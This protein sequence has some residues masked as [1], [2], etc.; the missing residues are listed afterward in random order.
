MAPFQ[1]PWTPAL[2]TKDNAHFSEYELPSEGGFDLSTSSEKWELFFCFLILLLCGKCFDV[3][4]KEPGSQRPSLWALGSSRR[5][6]R[7]QPGRAITLNFFRV[8]VVL[9]HG[10]FHLM[11]CYAPVV[12]EAPTWFNYS[13]LRCQSVFLVKSLCSTSPPFWSP[14]PKCNTELGR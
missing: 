11:P 14:S 2:K 6:S 3:L 7:I 5:V 4:D 8:G 1:F 9:S 12:R 10:H 13:G